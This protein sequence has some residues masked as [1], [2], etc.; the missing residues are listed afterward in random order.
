MA[1]P[2]WAVHSSKFQPISK[3][4]FE[5]E[6]VLPDFALSALERIFVCPALFAFGHKVEPIFTRRARARS[7][8][9]NSNRIKTELEIELELELRSS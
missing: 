7:L 2:A 3:F 4:D 8:D 9:S 5:I 6:K 1:V